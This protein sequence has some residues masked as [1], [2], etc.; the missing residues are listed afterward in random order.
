MYK[1]LQKFEKKFQHSYAY[2]F[3]TYIEMNT[4]YSL[5]GFCLFWLWFIMNNY[6]TPACLIFFK[7][8]TPVNDLMLVKFSL[9]DTVKKTR[10]ITGQSQIVI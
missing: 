4:L 9:Y 2:L 7:T 1:K 6:G 8:S 10:H 5:V 3:I